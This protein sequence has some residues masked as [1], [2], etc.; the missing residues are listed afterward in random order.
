MGLDYGIGIESERI[1]QFE[2]HSQSTFT[3]VVNFN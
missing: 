3:D 1:N 2:I